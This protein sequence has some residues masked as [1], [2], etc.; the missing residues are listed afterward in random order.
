MTTSGDSLHRAARGSLL[1]L[2]GS[3]VSGITTF[4]LTIA[5]TRLSSQSEAGVFFSATSLFLLAT[6]LGQLGTNTGLVYFI[7]GSR[8]RRELRHAKTYMRIAALPVLVAAVL[9]GLGVFALADPI[10]NLL[11][12][13]EEEQF[14]GYMRVMAMFVPCA[15]LLNLALAATRGLGTMQATAILDQMAK[16]LL[17]LLLVGVA[18]T[19]IGPGAVSWAWSAAYLPVAVVGWW[20]WTRLRDRAETQVSDPT[21]RPQRAFWRFSGPRALA[22]VTQVAMQRLDIILVGALAGL[23]AAAVYGAATR[24]L[25]LGQMVARAVSL[26]VQPL[27]GE[28]LA[29]RDFTDAQHLYQ[30]A[31]A[32]LILVTWPLYLVLIGFGE[33]VLGIFGDGYS[34]GLTALIVLCSAMLLATA[35]GM[36]NMVLVMAGKSFWNLTNILVAFTVNLGLDLLLIPSHGV[37]GAAIGWAAA[38][39]L[40]NI[41]PLSQVAHWFRLH[42]FGR[43]TTHAM[44]GCLLAFG[45]V[46]VGLRMT[47]LEGTTLFIVSMV[48]AGIL[49]AVFLG[50]FRRP[51]QLAVLINVLRNRRRA[52]RGDDLLTSD[53]PRGRG[54]QS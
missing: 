18:L 37:L 29:R 27:F 54:Y 41:L 40:G 31:T 45:V 48:V 49:Y 12:P 17:Q 24:F 47:P 36:V 44:G 53:A 6:S 34:V 22:G 43:G 15:A 20:W 9:I 2:L 42:P 39:V 3:L 7:S 50:T 4:V 51:L 5:V 13:G 52:R 33:T 35:C 10:G 8:A 23:Q 32:W 21:F 28:S 1:N 30:A 46:P 19:A 14:A 25:A 38:I 11:S 26:S 16:P